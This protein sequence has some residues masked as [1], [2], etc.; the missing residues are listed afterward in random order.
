MLRALLTWLLKQS[1]KVL[2]KVDMAYAYHL[3]DVAPWSLVRHSF[4]KVVEGPRKITSPEVYHAAGLAAA[5]VE[6]CGPCV[7]IHVNLAQREHVSADVLRNLVAHKLDQVP[8]EV[9][10]AF[11]FGEKVSRGELADEERDALRAKWGEKGL[12]E[13]AFATAVSRFYPALKRG[14]GYAHTC[15][16]VVV[17]NDVTLAVKTEAVKAA[18]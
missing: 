5:M 10:T 12:V 1:E 14:L 16:R 7:Q 4:I 15:E 6:D 13:L 9:A 17:G 11:R 18:A 2:G 3:R 8:R